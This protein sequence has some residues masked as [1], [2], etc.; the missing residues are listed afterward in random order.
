MGTSAYNALESSFQYSGG[1]TTVLVSYTYSKALDDSSAATEQIQPYDPQLEWALSLFNVTNNFV[2]SYSYQLPFD[3]LFS[4]ATRLTGGWVLSGITRFSSGFPVTITENDDRSLI[5]NTSVGPG[6][7]R[8]SRIT[9][10]ANF[11]RRPIRARAAHTSIHHFSAW[12]T[13]G[14]LETPNGAFSAGRVSTTG[15]WLS[16]RRYI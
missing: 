4:H 15:I 16:L 13:W 7:L 10:Q 9:P 2:T 6:G 5:G 8:T 14:N 11:L 3:K 1:R 12:R